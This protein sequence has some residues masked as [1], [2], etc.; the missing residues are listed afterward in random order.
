VLR[1]ASHMKSHTPYISM[2]LCF[3]LALLSVNP[4]YA[5]AAKQKEV[6][7]M[8]PMKYEGGSL[9][10]NQHDKLETFVSKEEVVLVQGKQRFAIPVKNITEV[11]YGNDVHRRVGAA[12]GVAAVTLGIGLMLLLVK[13][14]KH[15][16]GIVWGDRPLAT[17][18]AG[19]VAPM[20]AETTPVA[21]NTPA[22]A[23][24]TASGK[25]PAKGGVVF[26]VGKGEYR[27]FMAS[28]EGVAGIKAV[29]ADAVG[30]GGTSKQ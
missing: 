3:T 27:G 30:S 22:P 5:A 15:Y 11:S 16:V 17:A 29:N 23:S 7:V 19:A 9:P 14:K 20:S 8:T 18:T 26:K 10:L 4:G 1:I 12:I 6:G 2:F 13:T 24:A 28:I 21:A 25:D